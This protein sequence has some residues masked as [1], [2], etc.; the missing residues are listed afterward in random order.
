MLSCRFVEITMNVLLTG[1]TGYAGRG[2]AGVLKGP[3]WVRGLDVADRPTSVDE[4]IVGDITDLDTCRKALRGAEAMVLC[5]MAP[6]P[7]AYETPPLAYDVNVK[8]TA[9]LYHAAVEA[10]LK[11]VVLLSTAGVLLRDNRANPTCG[12]GPY[13]FNYGRYSLTKL[14]QE[15]IARHHY[16]ANGIAAAILRPAWIVYDEQLVTKYG[17]KVQYYTS[18]LI[19]PRDIGQAVLAALALPDLGLET[20]NLGQDDFDWDISDA[21]RRLGWKPKYRF[22]SLPKK[23]Q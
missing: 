8:G 2:L 5:H 3:H 14:M 10:G 16:E 22:S 9:N 7:T 20:F 17:D 4:L 13:N 18:H 1:A 6:N 15:I 19:D 23:S 21:Q 12:D 11:R